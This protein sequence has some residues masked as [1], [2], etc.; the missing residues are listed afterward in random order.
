MV[1]VVRARGDITDADRAVLT[2]KT[3]RRKLANEQKR[4]EHLVAREMQVCNVK[5]CPDFI[6]RCPE[7]TKLH[8]AA[9][10]CWQLCPDEMRQ[11]SLCAV[12]FAGRPRVGG[13]AAEGAGS[14]G[15]Q[16]PETART[17]A[18]KAGEQR[19]LDFL[20]QLVISMLDL[21]LCQ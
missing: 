9:F 10:N 1:P 13:Q 20:R 3:Q 17:A 4:L 2:L 16:A 11:I 12:V 8:S 18:G 7:C 19:C 6:S 15:A 5:S 14:A 21:S